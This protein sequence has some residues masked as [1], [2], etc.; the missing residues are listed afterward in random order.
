MIDY[1]KRLKEVVK[2]DASVQDIVSRFEEM[3]NF[4]TKKRSITRFM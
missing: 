2:E 4:L 1:I 3:C